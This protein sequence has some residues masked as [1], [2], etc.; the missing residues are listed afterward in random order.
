MRG[1]HQNGYPKVCR[2]YNPFGGVGHVFFQG[3]YQIRISWFPNFIFIVYD[4]I[5]LEVEFFAF[6][7]KY[8]E[9]GFGDIEDHLASPEPIG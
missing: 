7:V 5:F 9:F 3:G 2:L 8:N 6:S 1:F 4:G